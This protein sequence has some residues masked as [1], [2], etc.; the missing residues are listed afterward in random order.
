M[1][2][3]IEAS[4]VLYN[5]YADCTVHF[6]FS[7]T[8]E[9]CMYMYHNHCIHYCQGYTFRGT[10]ERNRRYTLLMMAN[11]PETVCTELSLFLFSL[12]HMVD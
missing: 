10:R 8:S 9:E 11:K 1:I 7:K 3:I 6:A 5:V 4:P 12:C 2:V